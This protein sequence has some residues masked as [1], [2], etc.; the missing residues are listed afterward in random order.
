[1]AQLDRATVFG[2]VDWGFESLPGHFDF[3]FFQKKAIIINMKKRIISVTL[4]FLLIVIPLF[5]SAQGL[6]PCGPG[7]GKEVCQLCDLFQLFANIVQFL[8]VV[9][10]PP[11]AALFFVWGGILFYTAM[12]DSSKITAARNVLTSVI[13]GIA[14]V[15]GAHFLVSMILNALGVVDVQWPNI[16]ISC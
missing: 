4:F 10:V 6:V 12:G 9:I 14:I 2:T 13:I 7:T 5:T 16:N 8:L 15:Y 3:P 11:V 1:M